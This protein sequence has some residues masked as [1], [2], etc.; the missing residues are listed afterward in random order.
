MALACSRVLQAGSWW[1]ASLRQRS[2]DHIR[3]L[4]DPCGLLRNRRIGLPQP[5]RETEIITNLKVDFPSIYRSD[6]SFFTGTEML[7][8]LSISKQ[9]SFII[10]TKIPIRKHPD[11]PVIK[12]RFS[13]LRFFDMLPVMMHFFSAA[14]FSSS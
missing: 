11:Q 7:M 4:P 3:A 14:S 8:L 1:T 10:K 12:N 5:N 13:V 6:Q 9:M 2:A